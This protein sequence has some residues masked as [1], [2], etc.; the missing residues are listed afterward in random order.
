M[1]KGAGYREALRLPSGCS[2]L[3]LNL[4]LLLHRGNVWLVAIQGGQSH[5]R[6]GSPAIADYIKRQGQLLTQIR[7]EFLANWCFMDAVIELEQGQLTWKTNAPQLI[8]SA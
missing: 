2:I 6:H 5:H 3:V 7:V 8:G 4:V 1:P